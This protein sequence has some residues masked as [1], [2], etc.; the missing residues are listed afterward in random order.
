[1]THPHT[2]FRLP[3]AAAA[4]SALALASTAQAA[5]VQVTVTVENLAPANSISFAPLHLGFNQGQ[6]D[7]F[8]A[9]Q[10][11][12]P[13]IVSVA[14]GGS[15]TVWQADFAAAEPN[16]VRGV[17]GMPLFP[18]QSR[19]AVFTVDASMNRFFTFASMVIPSNDYFIG[20]DSPTK[21]GLFD[22]NGQQQITSIDL[23]ASD[24]W[25]AGSEVFSVAGAA[26]LVNGNNDIRTAEN[27]VVGLDFAGLSGFNGETTA[28]GYVFDS[29]MAASTPIYRIGFA[30]AA[31][32]EPQTYVLMAV[33][34]LTLAGLSRRRAA[35]A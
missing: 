25:N 32:P 13:G 2:S 20:N 10:T 22:A 24:L 27:G 21:Y 18:G 8:N 35:R 3:L 33:G 12:T 9:G 29:Q 34:L 7:A 6:F 15:G 26:F 11:A 31:V 5:P 4:L 30:V 19:S 23:T 14:E 1:M 28:A 16:A 17:I